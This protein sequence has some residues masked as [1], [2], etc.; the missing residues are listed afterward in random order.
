[1]KRWKYIA[2]EKKEPGKSGD[3]NERGRE[4]CERGKKRA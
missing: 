1:V 2:R 4:A 3:G